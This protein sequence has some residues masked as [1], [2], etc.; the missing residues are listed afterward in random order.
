MIGKVEEYLG[1]LVR[2]EDWTLGVGLVSLKDSNNVLGCNV[3][4][5]VVDLASFVDIVT[6]SSLRCWF[7]ED[8]SLEW[9]SP[10]ASNIIVSKMNDLIFWNT[11]LL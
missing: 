9:V 5:F 2:L 1:V 8:F 10:A 6:W 11:L 4:T 3:P 7:V